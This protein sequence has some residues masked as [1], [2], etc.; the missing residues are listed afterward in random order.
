MDVNVTFH[1]ITEFDA[2][3]WT[4]EVFSLLGYATAQIGS[5]LTNIS[6]KLPVYIIKHTRG[7]GLNHTVAK[8]KVWHLDREFTWKGHTDEYDLK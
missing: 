2:E 8:A 7:E 5:V 3:F 4:V 6:N 1:E